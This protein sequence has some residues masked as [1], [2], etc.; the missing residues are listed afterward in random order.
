MSEYRGITRWAEN[1]VGMINWNDT[2]KEGTAQVTD[3][4]TGEV[5]QIGGGGS[6]LS[7]A[8]V[9]FVN[10]TQYPFVVELPIISGDSLYGYTTEGWITGD[11][12]V[13]LYNN[14][15]EGRI[16][17]ETDVT[18]NI[19]VTGDIEVEGT[20]VIITGDGTITIS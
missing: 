7:T 1:A 12:T 16:H 20:A 8:N 18:L 3:E 5:Y 4:K 11:K 9:T 14:S 2:A 10:N 6:N 19:T 17:P 15:C 13:V